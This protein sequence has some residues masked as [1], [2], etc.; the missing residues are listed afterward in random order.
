MLSEHGESLDRSIIF[1][2]LLP[3]CHVKTMGGILVREA[4]PLPES[5][6]VMVEADN[7]ALSQRLYRT[8]IRIS[9]RKKS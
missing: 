3:F 6:D 8:S 9:S 5:Q 1:S 7:L 2:D 4:V